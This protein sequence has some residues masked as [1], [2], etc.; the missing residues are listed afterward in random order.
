M[1]VNSVFNSSFEN[2]DT[3]CIA[4]GRPRRNLNQ[5]HIG[6]LY[7]NTS[8][9]VSFLHLAWHY[10]L[11][12]DYPSNK[13]LWLDL[14]LDPLNKA[15]LAA[16]CEMVYDT[17]KAGIPYGICLDGSGF[18]KNGKYTAEQIYAGLT[19]ATFVIQIFHSQGF[20]II[21]IPKWYH[22]QEDKIWQKQIIQALTAIAPEEHIQYQLRK[23]QKGSARFKPEEVAVAAVLPD[24]P[25]APE[26][27]KIPASKL[28]D[29]IIKHADSFELKHPTSA[30]P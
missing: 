28:L 22:K 18:A 17:N 15:H 1:K 16:V 23:I 2:I 3:I 26:P 25:Y 30:P 9:Q 6:L 8:N 11:R 5:Q 29:L 20:Y 4:I 7:I 27:L 12:N 21:D 19:C 24:Q 14:N 13:Y 10:E